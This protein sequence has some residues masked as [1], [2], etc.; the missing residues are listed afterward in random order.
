MF[1][2]F[3]THTLT[4]DMRNNKTALFCNT[5]ETLFTR[6]P[7]LSLVFMWSLCGRLTMAADELLL[8]PLGDG[9]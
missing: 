4:H 6:V 1:I 5:S 7:E 8:C 3:F 9:V 2:K